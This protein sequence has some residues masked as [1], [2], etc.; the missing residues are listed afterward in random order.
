MKKEKKKQ[1]NV[2]QALG[3]LE[4]RLNRLEKWPK[5]LEKQTENILEISKITSKPRKRQ[6]LATSM[7]K[8]EEYVLF[9]EMEFKEDIQEYVIAGVDKKRIRDIFQDVVYE[10]AKD[11][12]S[13]ALAASTPRGQKIIRNRRTISRIGAFPGYYF[14]FC[15]MFD[16]MSGNIAGAQ[17]EYLMGFGIMFGSSFLANLYGRGPVKNMKERM[18]EY[19]PKAEG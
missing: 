9:P 15:G 7:L 14:I 3:D 11:N 1:R 18:K 10:K 17:M 13:L 19:M 2:N 6:K 12:I 5:K 16:F 8:G 4:T